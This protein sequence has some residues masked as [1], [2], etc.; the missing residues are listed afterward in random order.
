MTRQSKVLGKEKANIQL[1]NNLHQHKVT[2]ST[3]HTKP[4]PF[5]SGA[6]QARELDTS[7]LEIGCRALERPIMDKN[8][9]RSRPR[10]NN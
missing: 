8:G 6:K 1:R 2:R 5:P 9:S 10:F 7:E 3:V 4:I